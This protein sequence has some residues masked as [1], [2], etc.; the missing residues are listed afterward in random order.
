MALTPPAM[1]I[2]A[3][4]HR[5][6]LVER[7]AAGF[8]WCFHAGN[9]EGAP[10]DSSIG[11]MGAQGWVRGFIPLILPNCRTTAGGTSINTKVL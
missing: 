3:V 8:W 9:G 1:P 4:V 2:G 7:V 6:Q 11:T 5:D 10:P